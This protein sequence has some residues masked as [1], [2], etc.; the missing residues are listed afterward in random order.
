MINNLTE[1]MII[2]LFNSAYKR[3][4]IKHPHVD[5]FFIKVTLFPM[6]DKREYYRNKIKYS[7]S[8]EI[9]EVFEKDKL[10]VTSK[11]LEIDHES[12]KNDPESVDKKDVKKVVTK[13]FV[14]VSKQEVLEKKINNKGVEERKISTVKIKYSREVLS[15]ING[16]IDVCVDGEEKLFRSNPFINH[17]I[18]NTKYN[19]LVDDI[20]KDVKKAKDDVINMMKNIKN[21]DDI[22]IMTSKME[23][24]FSLI[25]NINIPFSN[26]NNREFYNGSM[27]F[28]SLYKDY[29]LKHNCSNLSMDQF[30]K[31]IE[32]L[33]W[34]NESL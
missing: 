34:M 19:Q 23:E 14:K 21:T 15:K 33:I 12:C 10:P 28:L 22:K 27:R 1:D 4:K 31:E 8:E 6:A 9:K 20:I 2:S 11:D 18:T 32:E 13:D 17:K 5:D 24:M 25:K 3:A 30:V 7:G 16:I 29:I 26:I